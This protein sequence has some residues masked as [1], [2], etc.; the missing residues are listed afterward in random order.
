MAK[1]VKVSSKG[2]GKSKVE[3]TV[4]VVSGTPVVQQSSEAGSSKQLT[5]DTTEPVNTSL[6]YEKSVKILITY[7]EKAQANGGCFDFQ[8][9]STLRKAIQFFRF[10]NSKQEITEQQAESLLVNGVV[11]GQSR[12]AYTLDEASVLYEIITYVVKRRR[13][14]LTLASS[15]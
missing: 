7:V 15:A 8:E 9:A 14:Q 6:D 4:P 5:Q 3:D 12:G 1:S 10:P 2:K 11:R 13:E